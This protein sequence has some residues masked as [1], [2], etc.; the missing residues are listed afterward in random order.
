MFPRQMTKEHQLDALVNSPAPSKGLPF[1]GDLPLDAPFRPTLTG[2]PAVLI[3]SGCASHPSEGG[4]RRRLFNLAAMLRQIGWRPVLLY[5]DYLPGDFA[6]MRQW[7]GE[8]FYYQPY[9]PGSLKWMM[10]RLSRRC[11]LEHGRLRSWHRSRLYNW[12]SG[13]PQ[14]DAATARIPVDNYYEPAL[15][16]VIDELHR[17]YKFQAVIAQFVIMSRALLRFPGGDVKRL[18]DTHEVFALGDAWKTAAPSKL[19]LRISPEDEKTALRR[20]DSAIAIQHHDA[21]TLRREGIAAGVLGHPVEVVRDVR[22]ADAL[23][24]GTILFVSRGHPFDVAGLEWFAREVY[25]LLAAWLRPEQVVVAGMIKDVMN[26]RP[27]F[28]F[29]GRVADLP[30][31]YARNRVVMAPLHE[32]TGLKIKVVEALG[33]GKALV[34]TPFAAL[35]VEEGAGAAFVVAPTARDFAAALQRL[36]KDDRECI[37]LMEGALAF[38]RHWNKEQALALKSVLAMPLGITGK[39]GEFAES[40]PFE[41]EVQAQGAYS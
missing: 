37:R 2:Q 13:N 39:A 40:G 8:D 20:A 38:A 33:Y 35:G 36:L 17:R 19:W 32:G 21:A 1:D 16:P 34:A 26:P 27:P 22:A 24:S 14:E 12:G 5:T 9:R 31:L 18:I 3:V 11:A 15:D 23:G 4:N 28:R 25:P 29:L 30:D 10:K 41:Q 6:A 7:W